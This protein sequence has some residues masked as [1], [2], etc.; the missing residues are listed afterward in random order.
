MTRQTVIWVV[1]LV[2]LAY[3]AVVILR[4]TGLL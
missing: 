1:N 2:I 4:M 3:A